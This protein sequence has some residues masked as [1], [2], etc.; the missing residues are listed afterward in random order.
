MTSAMGLYDKS[1]QLGKVE[2]FLLQL[3]RGNFLLFRALG[4]WTVVAGQESRRC[5][6]A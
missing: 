1:C 2:S 6:R 4:L 3:V 5:L